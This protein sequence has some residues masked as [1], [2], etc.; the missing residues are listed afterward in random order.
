MISLVC[1]RSLRLSLSLWLP[2]PLKTPVSHLLSSPQSDTAATLHQHSGSGKIT[3]FRVSRF[4]Q[5]KV[6]RLSLTMNAEI[7]AEMKLIHLEI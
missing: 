2:L 3:A 5:I 6:T 1:P 4:A 7:L